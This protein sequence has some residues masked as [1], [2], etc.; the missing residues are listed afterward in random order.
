MLD[1]DRLV[2]RDI[3]GKADEIDKAQQRRCERDIVDS[4]TKRREAGL[5]VEESFLLLS[6][7]LAPLG[8]STKR[9][10]TNSATM[11]SKR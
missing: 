1:Y 10:D 9:I 3:D 5:G 8:H 4:L 6:L 2:R 11:V 7:H